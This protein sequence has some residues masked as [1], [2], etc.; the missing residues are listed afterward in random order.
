MESEP[1]SH[2]DDELSVRNSR[3]HGETKTDKGQWK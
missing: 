3:S 2:F 1:L